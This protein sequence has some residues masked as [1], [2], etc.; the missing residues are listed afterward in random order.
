MRKFDLE[1][2]KAGAPVCTREGRPVR[3]ICWNCNDNKYPI[4]GLVDYGRSERVFSYDKEGYNLSRRE[5]R[6]DDLVMAG[7][8]KEHND[9]Y[10][11]DFEKCQ[12]FNNGGF[13]DNYGFCRKKRQTC[14]GCRD[15][16]RKDEPV[17]I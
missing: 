17:E 2:A 8:E 15:L 4:I 13:T 3:I 7:K 1:E 9:F 11:E 16:A 6:S 10:L 12:C 5:V 14:D